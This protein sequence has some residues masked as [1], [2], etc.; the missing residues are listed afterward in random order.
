MRP[1]LTLEWL[2]LLLLLDL[3]EQSAVDVGQDTSES[4]GG[5]N[6]SV[7]FFVAANGELKMAGRDSL[8]LQI[9]CGVLLDIVSGVIRQIRKGMTHSCE[10]EDFSG[11][12]FEDSSHVNSSLGSYTHL[13]LSVVLEETLDTTAGELEL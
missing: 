11:Q 3:Q 13:V 2:V 9:L 5:A 1:N 10:F 4:D 12:V 8:D 6:K 7:E